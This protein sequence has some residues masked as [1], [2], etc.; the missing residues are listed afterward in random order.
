M[1]AAEIAIE[2]APAI[3]NGE[4]THMLGNAFSCGTIVS[5]PTE[6]RQT[7]QA[8]PADDSHRMTDEQWYPVTPQRVEYAHNALANELCKTIPAMRHTVENE[9]VNADYLR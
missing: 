6:N 2:Y 9:T 3:V 8:S 5:L 1:L 7:R 4:E